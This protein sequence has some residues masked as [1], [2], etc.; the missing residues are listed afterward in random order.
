MS[1]IGQNAVLTTCELASSGTRPKQLRIWKSTALH[2]TK[3]APCSTIP[4]REQLTIQ[5][6]PPKRCAS[7][8]WRCRIAEIFLSYVIV[9]GQPQFAYSVPDMRNRP[10]GEGM[11]LTRI[12]FANE[13]SLRFQPRD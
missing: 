12:E 8:R 5:I 7:P 9:T 10:S 1:C 13:I 2:L 11:N 6:T 4:Y 3:P